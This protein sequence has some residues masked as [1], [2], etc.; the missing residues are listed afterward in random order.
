[1][2]QLERRQ[3]KSLRARHLRRGNPAFSDYKKHI[4][5]NSKELDDYLGSVYVMFPEL[6]IEG[7]NPDQAAIEEVVTIRDR[8]IKSG[9]AI[10]PALQMAVNEVAIKK[11]WIY[12]ASAPTTTTYAAPASRPQTPYPDCVIRQTMT[13]ADYAACGITPPS[14]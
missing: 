4:L 5:E 2:G 10:I 14:R 9:S 13:D 11:R 3:R 1:M 7:S 12:P 8:H 6:N